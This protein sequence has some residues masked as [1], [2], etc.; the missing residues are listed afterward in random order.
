[1]MKVTVPPIIPF[2]EVVFTFRLI[3]YNETFSTLMPSNKTSR[4]VRKTLQKSASACVLWHEAL[5]GR[6]A[7]EVAG[8]NLMG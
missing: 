2:K 7:E 8:Y 3:C 5:A 4:S 6:S 1:M